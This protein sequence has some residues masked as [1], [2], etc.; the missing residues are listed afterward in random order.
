[1]DTFAIQYLEPGPHIAAL[2]AREVGARLRDALDRLPLRRVIVGWDIPELLLDACAG[3]C[4]ARDVEL[5]RWQ[6]LLTGDGVLHPRPEWQVI[7]LNGER[8]PGFHEMPEF[9]FM[10]PNRPGVLA[11]AL[12]RLRTTLAD[13]R[14]DG[15]F[16][17]RIRF[18]SPAENPSAALGCFCADCR[19]VAAAHDLDLDAVRTA[20]QRLLDTSEGTSTLVTGLLDKSHLDTGQAKAKALRVFLQ[21]REDRVSDFV[22]QTAEAARALGKGIGLDCFTPALTGLVGQNLNELHRYGDWVK[23]MSYGHALGPSGLPFELGALADWLVIDRG[24]TEAQAM[25]LLTTG[26]GLTLPETRAALRRDGV[27]AAGLKREVERASQAG[28]NNVLAGI[29]LVEIPGVCELTET[30]IT[31]DLRA[32]REGGADGLALSWD[33][34]HMPPARL[35]LVREGWA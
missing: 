18:P 6:P 7:G 17:D 5:Y 25:S 29:E 8:V 35:S 13:D 34:W 16:L 20:L 12:D 24:M 10:C 33:L 15:V 23:I 22:R 1:V 28:L 31:A 26:S 30:Q 21:F 27:P 14:Y 19:R 4:R 3:E 9:T 32:F 11:A 2:S